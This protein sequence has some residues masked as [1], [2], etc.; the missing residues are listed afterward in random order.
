LI[1]QSN[2]QI[3][4]LLLVILLAST[5]ISSVE[6]QCRE[7]DHQFI[8]FDTKKQGFSNLLSIRLHRPHE[9][10]SHLSC[11]QYLKSVRGGT[12]AAAEEEEE[13][14]SGS[15]K[16]SKSRKK[17]R[18]KTHN[19]SP[20]EKR[21]SRRQIEKAMKPSNKT[22]DVLADSMRQAILDRAHILRNDPPFLNNAQHAPAY[23][24]SIHSIGY[25]MGMTPLPKYPRPKKR[26]A[27][28]AKYNE[29]ELSTRVDIL[30]ET[31]LAMEDLRS[32]ILANYIFQSHGGTHLLQT[33]ASIL[34]SLTG[35][36]A[37]I[38]ALSNDPKEMQMCFLLLKQCAAMGMIKH[39]M[40]V[41]GM[42]LL[43]AR[44]IPQQGLYQTRRVVEQ[45]VQSREDG[46]VTR[47]LFY[48]SWL[49]LWS[50]N[51]RPW[52]LSSIV[53]PAARLLTTLCLLGPILLREIIH[54]I[55]VL[56]D[57]LK[58]L[59]SY[60]PPNNRKDLASSISKA[61]LSLT[62]ASIDQIMNPL[63]RSF[64]AGDETTPWTHAHAIQ[65]QKILAVGITKFSGL[66]ELYTAFL[67]G[68]DVT[69][70]FLQ[71]VG[72]VPEQLL[73]GILDAN[74]S[75]LRPKP[76][77]PTLIKSALLARLYLNFL[78]FQTGGHA[79]VRKKKKETIW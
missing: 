31:D 23:D 50:G 76:A 62:S 14:D 36:S 6:S 22:G 70:M 49:V 63:L 46:A 78:F 33:M 15:S 38:L 64:V 2:Y 32:A 66:L 18:K 35:I 39:G 52:Y 67:V 3:M 55:W 71:F 24:I 13:S 8:K 53:P 1:K 60:T 48:C 4:L 72:F 34:A 74:T 10:P 51:E 75:T 21:E 25:G 5:N 27:E 28:V 26:K 30:L 59:S 69:S 68:L 45:L 7:I 56:S 54:V 44:N 9:H 41:I 42:V 11:L 19:Q 47:Y 58:I 79:D 12:A 16:K 29:E 43:S 17:K 61:I 57:V 20:E 37:C 40:G 73:V 77:I 65:K